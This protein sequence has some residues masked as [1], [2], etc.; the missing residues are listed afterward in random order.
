MFESVIKENRLLINA[1]KTKNKNRNVYRMLNKLKTYK[2]NA[3]VN[4]I[5]HLK[6]NDKAKNTKML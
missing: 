5:I 6:D 3:F 1:G 4:Y 2:E